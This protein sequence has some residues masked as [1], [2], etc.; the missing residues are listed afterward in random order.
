MYTEIIRVFEMKKISFAAILFAAALLFTACETQAVPDGTETTRAETTAPPVTETAVDTDTD[1]ETEP[2]TTEASTETKTETEEITDAGTETESVTDAPGLSYADAYTS[3]GFLRYLSDNYG[4]SVS[5]SIRAAASGGVY[6][7]GIYYSLTGKSVY[8]LFDEYRDVTYK[9]SRTVT[10]ADG[11]V[12]RLG[13]C[14]DIMLAD[15]QTVMNNYI[16]SGKDVS[17]LVSADLLAIMKSCDVLMANNEFTVSTRGTKQNK[18][19][20]F[21]GA[22]E[23]L[24]IYHELGVDFVSAANNHVYD[25][26]LEAFLDTIDALEEYGVD[27][28]GAGRNIKEASEPFIYIINGRKIAVL[29]GSRAE[30]NRKTPTADEDFPGVFGM[31]DDAGMI[32]A[33]KKADSEC[34]LVIILAHWGKEFSSEIED[35]IRVQGRRYTDAGADLIIGAHAH[36]LQGMEFYKD[37]FIAYNLGNFLFADPGIKTGMLQIDI[38]AA[39]LTFSA[40]FMPCIQDTDRVWLCKGSEKTEVLSYMRSVSPDVRIDDDGH[41]TAKN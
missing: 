14:G 23:N 5:E 33:V 38:D 7:E 19:F 34:D 17:A 25:Y 2:A 8:V 28:A 29:C 1:A 9:K 40:D 16:N 32:E 39:T 10:A 20:T 12:I 15:G 3:S 30:K 4:Q 35:V 6:D 37:G 22:P 26:G 41:I 11:G 24:S 18:S 31:Y 27:S 21:R 36:R 13:F